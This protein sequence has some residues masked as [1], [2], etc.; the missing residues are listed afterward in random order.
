MTSI[1]G[2]MQIDK[3]VTLTGKNAELALN[4][5]GHYSQYPPTSS[6]TTPS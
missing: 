5:G 4:S 3:N 6:A 1:M 2:A